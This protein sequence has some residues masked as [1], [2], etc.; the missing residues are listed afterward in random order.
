MAW[1]RRKVGLMPFALFLLFFFPSQFKGFSTERARLGTFRCF[2]T[3]R[4]RL[5]TFR[6]FGTERA[7]LDTF[8]FLFSFF[9]FHFFSFTPDSRFS[10]L[11]LDFCPLKKVLKIFADISLK[12][13]L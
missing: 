2:G 7:R 4:A 11:K 1:W 12:T 8:L 5:G 9:I 13:L 10:N 3:E 6:G